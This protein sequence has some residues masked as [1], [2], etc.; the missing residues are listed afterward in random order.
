MIKIFTTIS[1]QAKILIAGNDLVQN[2]IKSLKKKKTEEEE[3]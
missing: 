2:K 3:G 1:V